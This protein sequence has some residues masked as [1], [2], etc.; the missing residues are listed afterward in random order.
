MKSGIRSYSCVICVI[1]SLELSVVCLAF[2]LA[3]NFTHSASVHFVDS[4]DFA[5][6]GA[7]YVRVENAGVA[8]QYAAIK[9]IILQL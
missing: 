8:K 2:S 5:G 4:L 3:L 7:E 1:L 9:P 6:G